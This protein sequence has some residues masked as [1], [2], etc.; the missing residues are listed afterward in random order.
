MEEVRGKDWFE[1]FLPHDERPPVRNLFSQALGGIPT[2]GNISSIV[3]K[4]GRQRLIEW[5]D[6]TLKNAE[7]EVIG[8]VAVGQDITERIKAREALQRA[9]DELET[10][11]EERTADIRLAAERE[12][13]LQAQLARIERI[14]TMGEMA[15]GLAHELNQPMAAIV[16]EIEAVLQ[17]ARS[18][19]EKTSP[20]LLKSLE[21]VAGQA[22]RAGS[23]IRR[24][25]EFAKSNTP[26]RIRLAVT[27]AVEEVL[28]FAQRDLRESGSRFEL[29]K[30]TRHRLK[31]W[32]IRSNY[33]KFFS[34]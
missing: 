33:N 3:M 6:N 21:F 28:G 22:H 11:V 20:A 10:R 17:K 26:K 8:I 13:N 7:G 31:S 12:A 4:D 19:Y 29:E 24:M 25:K 30:S 2:S 16:L 32:P 14:H 5:Y 15:S 23:L 34:T 1:A 18:G 9:H 27:D